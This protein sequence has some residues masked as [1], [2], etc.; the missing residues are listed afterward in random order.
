MNNIGSTHAHLRHNLL[1]L[2]SFVYNLPEDD[3]VDA[4]TCRTDITND[5]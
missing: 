5:K 4:E 2:Y 3:L 1:H